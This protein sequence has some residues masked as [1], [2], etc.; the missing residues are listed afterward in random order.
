MHLFLAET[1]FYGI[2]IDLFSMVKLVIDSNLQFESYTLKFVVNTFVMASTSAAKW[3]C[4]TDAVAF[5]SAHF[6]AGTGTI[7][8]D[9]VGCTGSETNLTDCSRSSTV[10]CTYGHMEDAGVRCQG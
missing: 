6:G 10:S 4:E 2:Q 1:N 3:F 8:L 7:Y 5:S 9:N